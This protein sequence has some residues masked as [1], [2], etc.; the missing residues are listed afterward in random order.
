M[1]EQQLVER[2]HIF[3]ALKDQLSMAQ[4][5]MKKYANKKRREVKFDEGGMVFLKLRPYRQQSL[6]QKRW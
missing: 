6:A 4:A 5:R 2:D 3:L 1:V